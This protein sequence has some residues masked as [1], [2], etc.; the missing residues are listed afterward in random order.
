MR[1]RS[2]VTPEGTRHTWRRGADPP[3]PLPPAVVA[4]RPVV[5][6]LNFSVLDDWVRP[7]SPAAPYSSSCAMAQIFLPL[8]PFLWYQSM[9]FAAST[10]YG[11]AMGIRFFSL[12]QSESSV[13]GPPNPFSAFSLVRIDFTIC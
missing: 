3:G 2:E 7:S 11:A 1:C 13:A 8:P 5:A 12:T 10:W 4:N 9:T 6:T